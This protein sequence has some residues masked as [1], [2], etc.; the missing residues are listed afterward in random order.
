VQCEFA[1]LSAGNAARLDGLDGPAT[2]DDEAD[3][4]NEGRIGGQQK[5]DG[6]QTVLHRMPSGRAARPG[7][8]EGYHRGFADLVGA[9]RG[10]EVTQPGF[11]SRD[12]D[13]RQRMIHELRSPAERLDRII[14]V[15]HQEDFTDRTLFPAECVL[16]KEGTRTTVEKVS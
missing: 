3:A 15:S 11:G 2:V 7:P 16:R 6:G 10:A 9:Q 4:G 14:V 1:D 13:G 12:A 5:P 8:A